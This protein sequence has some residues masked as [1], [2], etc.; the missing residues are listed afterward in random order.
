MPRSTSPL[1]AGR[2]AVAGLLAA[3]CLI[4]PST[5]RAADP[6][7]ATRDQ[8]AAALKK[9]VGFYHGKVAAHGGYLYRYSADLTKREGEGVAA[10]DTVWVQPPGTPAVGSAYLDAYERTGE[11]YLLDAARD[12]G[13]CLVRGQLRSGGWTGRIDFDPALRKK[14][15]YRVDPAPK[16]GGKSRFD[17]STFDDDKTQSAVRFLARLDK[18]LNFKDEQVHEA[19]TFALNSILRAQ[20]PSGA[21]G[22]GWQDFPAESPDA[23]AKYPVKPASYPAEWPRAYPGEKFWWFYTFNDN[24][25]ADTIDT[26]LL[27]TRVYGEPKYRDAAVKAGRFMLL[28]QMPAPQPAWAQQYDF[29]MRP[30]W[31]RKFEPPAISG[32]ESQGI[33]AALMTIYAETGDRAFLAPI[34]KAMAYL[35]TCQLPDGRLAR[36]YELQTNKPLYFTKAYE[37]THDGSDVP[38]HYGFT[39]ASKL[40]ELQRKHDK[41]SAM[42]AE[43]LA[44]LRAPKPDKAKVDGAKADGGKAAAALAQEARAAIAALDERGAW[45]EDGRLK[46]HPKNDPTNRVITSETFIKNAGVLSRYLATAK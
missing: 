45:V 17:V 36:F 24:G 13:R 3:A 21:W 33:I 39:V 9:A 12:A 4:L 19:A 23:A 11:A 34:P 31:A 42:S 15:A 32:G 8:A 41:V 22:Q 6:P 2:L 5:A 14:T 28:A 44:E 27:A 35:R 40:D 43:Q 1:T 18:A 46:Y 26:L 10:A 38:T 29:D 25:I 20:F 37:L 16:P 30:V 7:A